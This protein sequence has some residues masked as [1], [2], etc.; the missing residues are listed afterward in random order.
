[1]LVPDGFYS[2]DQS[3]DEYPVQTGCWPQLMK[4]THSAPAPA[5]R[6]RRLNIA[7]GD[8]V[9]VNELGIVRYIG[10]V[11]F[12][13][14]RWVG[15]ELKTSQGDHS[16][17]VHGRRYFECKPGHGILVQEH[18][19]RK[20]VSPEE[21]LQKV[22]FL[23]DEL[24]SK[25][26]ENT[27]LK[28][29]L[30][31]LEAA[32][33]TIEL[34]PV[35][36]RSF[37]PHKRF[38]HAGTIVSSAGTSPRGS[39]ISI[40]EPHPALED[41]G[42]EDRELSPSPVTP[43]SEAIIISDANRRPVM[44]PT[45]SL[46]TA[47]RPLPRP[48]FPRVMSSPAPIIRR[49]SASSC[50]GDDVR[51]LA[52]DRLKVSQLRKEL[53][54]K[55]AEL[56]KRLKEADAEKAK[57][58]VL[59][60]KA[61][62]QSRKFSKQQAETVRDRKEL[63]ELQAKLEEDRAETSRKLANA[64]AMKEKAAQAQARLL[65]QQKKALSDAKSLETRRRKLVEDEKSM[66]SERTALSE[67]RKEHAKQQAEF[68]KKKALVE[69]RLE[70]QRGEIERR[71]KS[72]AMHNKNLEVNRTALRKATLTGSQEPDESLAVD[73]QIREGLLS[74]RSFLRNLRT[75]KQ[76]DVKREKRPRSILV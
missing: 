5:R 73:P 44:S 48:G 20:S 64:R 41:R 68:S 36:R 55:E 21:L 27:T 23:A 22:G 43:N 57:W 72:L 18:Q 6:A 75:M 70:V 51:K 26:E 46:D 10:K 42:L 67:E 61:A 17:I 19:V 39:T 8:V 63:K 59:N 54:S 58:R 2:S 74:V 11:H 53:E 4:D 37:S 40:L 38:S 1:M 16:G 31:E 15:I 47:Q 49:S 24:L 33:G 60:E 9:V 50:A 29:K 52:R 32:G 12:S 66:L 62:K 45:P 76:L 30:E 34:D 35:T 71:T 56:D 7:V 65:K 25:E 28:R 69:K 14:G 3:D 13:N